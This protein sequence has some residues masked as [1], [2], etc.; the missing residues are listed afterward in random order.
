MPRG[1]NGEKRPAD[2]IGLA[3]MVGRIATG[4]E[5]DATLASKNRRK[6]GIAGAEARMKNTGSSYNGKVGAD[7][8]A[9]K[10]TTIGVVVSGFS[11]PST[12][13]NRNKTNNSLF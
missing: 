3:V 13:V 12:F 5:V 2:A 6:S 9:A 4:E 10:N 8:F 7:Y 11:N 1:P